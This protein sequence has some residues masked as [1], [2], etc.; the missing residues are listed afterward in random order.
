LAELNSVYSLEILANLL[1]NEQD[2]MAIAPIASVCAIVDDRL[3]SILLELCESPELP[4]RSHAAVLVSLGAQRNPDDLQF[5]LSVAQNDELVGQ[6]GIIRGG[7]LK[8]KS[9]CKKIYVDMYN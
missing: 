8:G 4:Y 2:P 9:F 7:A 5:L 3:R 6:H 1:K